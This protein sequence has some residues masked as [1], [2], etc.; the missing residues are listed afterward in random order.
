LGKRGKKSTLIQPDKRHRNYCRK[1]KTGF[2]GEKSACS[3]PLKTMS[4][5]NLGL[6]GR[7]TRGKRGSHAFG[8]RR[9]SETV[10]Q[11]KTGASPMG[12]AWQGGKEEEGPSN[13]S[14]KL[15][16]AAKGDY[17]PRSQNK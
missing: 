5:E 16:L 7:L 1:R 14:R 13:I 9:R 4:H 8:N 12:N 17:E 11:A 2:F 3:K 6:G 15:M 10:S